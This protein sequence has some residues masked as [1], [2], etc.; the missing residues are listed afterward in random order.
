[1]LIL[2]NQCGLECKPAESCTIGKV[3]SAYHPTRSIIFSDMVY[4]D[5]AKLQETPAHMKQL[6][7]VSG[8]AW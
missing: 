7:V 8:V 1:M 2:V 3:D 6:Y 5:H 4:W